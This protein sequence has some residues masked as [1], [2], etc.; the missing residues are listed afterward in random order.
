VERAYW[1]TTSVGPFRE[2]QVVVLDDEREPDAGWI[3]TGWLRE[4]PRPAI[5]VTTA[6]LDQWAAEAESGFPVERLRDRPAWAKH[7]RRR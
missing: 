7:T 3:R 2:F 1:A 4:I 6:L 5:R